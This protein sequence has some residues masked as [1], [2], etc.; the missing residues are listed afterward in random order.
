MDIVCIS[1]RSVDVDG[2][3]WIDLG[4]PSSPYE[5]EV[6][7]QRSL[8]QD[9]ALMKDGDEN[10]NPFAAQSTPK[11]P[12]KVFAANLEPMSEPEPELPL[13]REQRQQDMPTCQQSMKNKSTGKVQRAPKSHFPDPA[14][15]TKAAKSKEVGACCSFYVLITYLTA[16]CW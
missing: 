7:P 14:A 8:N 9:A 12:L 11:S 2:D 6:A 3:E 10:N 15:M 13:L 5:A 4:P 16:L 1:G